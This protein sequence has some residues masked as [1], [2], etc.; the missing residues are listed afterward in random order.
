MHMIMADDDEFRVS[1]EEFWESLAGKDTNTEG[2]VEDQDCILRTWPYKF[3]FGK[4]QGLTFDEVPVAYV[5][6][7]VQNEINFDRE[8]FRAALDEYR[9]TQQAKV[10]LLSPTSPNAKRK[11][12][13]SGTGVP[14]SPAIVKKQRSS[15]QDRA[16]SKDDCQIPEV[17]GPSSNLYRLSFGKHAGK[18]LE[19]LPSSYIEWLLKNGILKSNPDLA[20]ALKKTGHSRL[21]NWTKPNP[22][23][24]HDPRF[25]D[26][27][28]NAALWIAKTDAEKY[29]NVDVH[30]LGLARIWPLVKRGQRYGL[31]PIYVCAKHFR[32]VTEGTADQALAEFLEKNR[33]REQEIVAGMGCFCPHCCGEDSY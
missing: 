15:P 13:F 33:Y 30:L 5:D 21:A 17:A 8:N 3:D 2:L 10:Q 29:F 32:T 22:Q 1:D 31:Y 11:R 14:L 27:D 12:S 9:G 6:W 26:R 28:T 19:E 4:H 24:T 25:F 18:T 23:D 20:S 7:L 16:F